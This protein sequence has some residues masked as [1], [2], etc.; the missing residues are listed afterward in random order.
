MLLTMHHIIS[1]GWSLGVFVREMG[2]IYAALVEGR[3]SELPPLPIQY[4]DFAACQRKWLSGEE[5][6][7]QL[8]YWKKKMANLPEVLELP[9]DHARPLR[10]RFLGATHIFV[11]P[12]ATAGQLREIA[13][14]QGATLFV[15]LLATFKVLLGR[16][17]H[18]DDLLVGS[19]IANR[20]RVEIEG[21]IGF[22]VNTLLFRTDLSGNP[23]CRELVQRVHQTAVEA[24][25]HQDLPFEKLVEELAPER[26]LSRNP[27]FQVTVSFLNAARAG[28]DVGNLRMTPLSVDRGFTHFD[29]T[30]T[31]GEIEEGALGL[32]AAGPDRPA[33]G[34]VASFNYNPEL[35]TAETIER[36]AGHF[37]GLSAR[38][39]ASPDTPI[40]QIT[41]LDAGDRH[42]MLVSWNDT[43]TAYPRRQTVHALFEAQAAHYHEAPALIYLDP[44][45]NNDRSLTYRELNRRANRLA[46][47]LKPG[48][49][50]LVGIFLERSPEMI[51]AM[52]AILKAGC[53]TF[54]S[55]PT[56]RL[57][58]WPS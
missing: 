58:V 47:S 16:Y 56:I 35:F 45:G 39:A 7:R 25:A 24:Y 18:R 37:K 50:R 19:P 4:A 46:R 10:R 33:G 55:I 40:D 17:T 21:L 3:E 42:R 15:T 34:I 9:A 54:R 51:L 8:G 26:D 29:L 5:L 6:D 13:R 52:L 20:N 22:F 31:L 38:L 41:L 30:L 48:P 2:M 44:N 43:A 12:P 28:G 36:L 32:C 23:T 57:N 11:L 14:S 49:D 1:D 27:L 53:V